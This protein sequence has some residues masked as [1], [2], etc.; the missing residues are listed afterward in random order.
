[1]PSDVEEDL[2]A[3]SDGDDTNELISQAKTKKP[4]APKRLS[5]AKSISKKKTK[6]TYDSGMPTLG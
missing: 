3:D 1:M 6:K 5:T 4:T 2:F